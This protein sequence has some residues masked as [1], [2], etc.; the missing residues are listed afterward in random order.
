[1]LDSSDIDALA[2]AQHSDDPK[3]DLNRDGAVNGDDHQ[4]WVEELK[5]TY[6]GDANLDGEFNTNDLVQVFQAGKY[7]K[8]IAHHASWSEGDWNGD[9]LFNTSDMVAAFQG[10]G[11]EN[12]VR[13]TAQPV[14]ELASSVL[15]VLGVVFLAMTKR[16]SVRQMT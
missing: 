2:I 3:F 6:F 1:M 11:F 8:P 9:S 7:E 14:P 15:V 5:Q 4:Y 12:G 10:G 13:S 16:R